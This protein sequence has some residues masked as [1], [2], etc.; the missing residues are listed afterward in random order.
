VNLDFESYTNGGALLPGWEATPVAIWQTA[1]VPADAT[2]IEFTVIQL[3][4]DDVEYNF[5][6]GDISLIEGTPVVVRGAGWSW[7]DAVRYTTPIGS[8]AGQTTTLVFEALFTGDGGGSPATWHG[9]DDIRFVTVP[10]PGALALAV[11][12][13]V[14]TLA[15]RRSRSRRSATL[16]GNE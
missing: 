16:P 12:G 2:H 3:Q 7:R 15:C 4:P 14:M 6:L 5:R 8:L 9:L 10:E 11:L 13:A 1:Q